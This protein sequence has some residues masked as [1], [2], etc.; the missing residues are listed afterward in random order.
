MKH[1]LRTLALFA[2]FGLAGAGCQASQV[3]TVAA[4]STAPAATSTAAGAGTAGSPAASA[5][6]V[7]TAAATSTAAAV[8]DVGV[9]ADCASAQPQVLRREPA[10]ITLTCADAGIGVQN[11]IWTDWSAAGA[12]GSGLLWENQCA[13]SCAAG[14]YT[15]Y[16]VAVTL[17]AVKTSARG[18]WFSRLTITWE[19]SRP[20]N[21]TP[22]AYTLMAP[23]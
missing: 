1:P 22:D 13:P 23:G 16:P 15:H 10:S 8:A 6:S 12:A 21:A 3:S 5:G 19:G 9:V 2:V 17:S 4:G 18:R 20:P 14:K 7:T 11:L